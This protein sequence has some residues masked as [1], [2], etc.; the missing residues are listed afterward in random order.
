MSKDIFK[1]YSYFYSS[2]S[3]RVRIGM[4]LKELDYEYIGVDLRKGE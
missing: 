3:W 2:A 1:L 4:N